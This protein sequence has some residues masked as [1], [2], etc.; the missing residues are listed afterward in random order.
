M[1]NF[2]AGHYFLTVLAPI[3]MDPEMRDNRNRSRRHL[4]RETLAAMPSGE[5]TAA[6]RNR[7][8]DNP[9]ARTTRTH[10]ARFVV[11]D[12]VV[13]NGRVP[14]DTLLDRISGG[15]PLVPQPVDRLTTPFLIFVADFDAATGSDKERDAYLSGLW[16]SMSTELTGIFRHCVGFEN[17]KTAEDFCRYIGKC[18]IE[19][20]MPF[21]DYW[22]APPALKNITILPFAIGTLGG[23][24]LLLA[25]VILLLCAVI[26][27]LLML[28]YGERFLSYGSIGLAV[29]LVLAILG[30][31]SGIRAVTRQAQIPFPA[32]APPAPASD[33]PTVLKSLYVQR[34]FTTLAI[35]T[36]GKSDK[37]LYD[38]FGAFLAKTQPM[39]LGAPTQPPGVIGV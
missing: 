39:N 37:E 30:V 15:D 27:A 11:L 35:E 7:V 16:N 29:G 38:E 34:A 1:P 17:V 19:T 20:T 24:L 3:R 14:S 18:Q 36:Q 22:S 33:L 26:L 10:F 9:F 21:N 6:S 2:D 31:I 4:I 32:S 12:D 25:G 23:A 28:P 8:Q 5:K 13:F